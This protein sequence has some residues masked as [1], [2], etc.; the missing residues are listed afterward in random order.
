MGQAQAQDAAQRAY[1][2]DAAGAAE[3]PVAQ[4]AQA[5]DLLGNGAITEAEF[6]TL[7]AKALA[8]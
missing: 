2:R 6:N 3:D 7:K 5:K 4:I 8:T 1:I